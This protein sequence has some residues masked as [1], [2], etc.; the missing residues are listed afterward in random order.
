MTASL[1]GANEAH[2][3]RMRTTSAAVTLGSLG[4]RV[5]GHIHSEAEHLFY[6]FW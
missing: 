1:P 3:S 2:L 6:Q 5:D 4:I